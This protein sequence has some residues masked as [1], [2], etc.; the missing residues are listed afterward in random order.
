MYPFVIKFD[1]LIKIGHQIIDFKL[2]LY[3][4]N[5]YI[6]NQYMGVFNKFSLLITC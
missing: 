2:L 5:K 1:V 6:T 3:N 4:C